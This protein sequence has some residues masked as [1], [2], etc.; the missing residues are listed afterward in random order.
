SRRRAAR[1]S[2]RLRK[3][4]AAPPSPALPDRS[5]TADNPALVCP[6]VPLPAVKLRPNGP[7]FPPPAA[8]VPRPD[9]KV[10]DVSSRSLKSRAAAAAA[11]ALARQGFVTPVDVCLGLGWLHASN[12]DDWRRGRVDDL[13]DFLPVHGDTITE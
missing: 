2:P 1:G 7:R 13:E 3:K 12:V 11:E 8:M 4:H 9:S 10:P 5:L 6:P